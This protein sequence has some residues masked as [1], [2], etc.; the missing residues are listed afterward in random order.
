M[1]QVFRVFAFSLAIMTGLIGVGVWA[2]KAYSEP[3][4]SLPVLRLGGNFELQ[5]DTGASRQLTEWRGR[6]VL[7]S[8]GFTHCPDICPMTLARYRAVLKALS[9]DA[10][11]LQPILISVDPARDSGKVLG[12]YVRY[13]DPRIVGLTG[14][15]SVLTAVE[16]LYGA[17]V[18]LSAPGE[19]VSVS[20]SDYLY[21]LDDLGRVRK[22]FDQQASV[23]AIVQDIR[24]LQREADAR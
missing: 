11:R 6:M 23:A 22:L 3:E 15:L 10:D 17:Q 1:S 21:L 19:P 9:D 2:K 4:V 12:D 7:L 16:R 8:F 5:D 24:I 14:S 20:H 18:V 13:F